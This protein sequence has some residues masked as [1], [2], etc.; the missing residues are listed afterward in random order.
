M[1][2]NPSTCQNRVERALQFIDRQSYLARMERKLQNDLRQE[3]RQVRQE[4]HNNRAR[5]SSSKTSPSLHTTTAHSSCSSS[6]ELPP[7]K[8]HRIMSRLSHPF[9]S[10][11]TSL[12]A[13]SGISSSSSSSPTLIAIGYHECI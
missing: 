4:H 3:R 10:R 11:G 6:I 12:E 9:H 7:T 5:S 1:E 13:S 8:I 2:K